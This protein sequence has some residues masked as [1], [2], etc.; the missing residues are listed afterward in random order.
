[1]TT[2]LGL[3]AGTAAY[4]GVGVVLRGGFRFAR[5]F[6]LCG[7]SS[8]AQHEAEALAGERRRQ[9]SFSAETYRV[10]QQ[11]LSELRPPSR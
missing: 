3:L 2:V 5:E 7:E 10:T 6:E 11:S 9:N 1:M 8:E 4:F